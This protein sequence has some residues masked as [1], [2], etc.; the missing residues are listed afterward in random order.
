MRAAILGAGLFAGLVSAAC[1][2]SEAH[3]VTPEGQLPPEP[4]G[5][6]VEVAELEVSYSGIDRFTSCP[7]PGEL[8]QDWIPPLPP[9]T[10]PSTSG[11]KETAAPTPEDASL[12]GKRPTDIAIEETRVPFR[13]CWHRSLVYDPTQN[14]HVAIV[15]R[16]GR[17]GRVAQVESYGAC[18]LST[19]A[20]QCMKDAAKRVRFSPPAGGSDTIT[21]P[22]VFSADTISRV[23]PLPADVYAASVYVV[24]EG[25]RPALHAC[26]SDA[27]QRGASVFA[28][29]TF[30][31]TLSGDGKVTHTNIDPWSGD[32]S[33]LSCAAQAVQSAQFPPPP[34]GAATI[35]SRIAFNPR[36]GTK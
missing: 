3:P 10:P 12:R 9:W 8:G 29:G 15:L 34:G 36:A 13:T 19:Q 18:D 23:T 32:Q 33:L 25:L 7:P 16:V 20:I 5:T 24:I 6:N 21:V 30:T 22:A 26:E 4:H 31:L 27:R 14:G 17:D 11:S 2:S 35:L 1:G 28:S